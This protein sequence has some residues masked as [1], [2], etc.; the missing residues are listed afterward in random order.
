MGLTA[1]LKPVSVPSFLTLLVYAT[2]PYF[3][4]IPSK[5]SFI[6]SSYLFIYLDC[7]FNL[8]MLG[9]L[10][11]NYCKC[12][13]DTLTLIDLSAVLFLVYSCLNLN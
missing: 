12:L 8:S 1:Y 7:A 11:L 4:L 6:M 5:L 3:T 10:L 13:S 2:L 9:L